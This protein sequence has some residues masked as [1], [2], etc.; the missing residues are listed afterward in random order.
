MYSKLDFKKNLQ[1]KTGIMLWRGKICGERNPMYPW[2]EL[3]FAKPHDFGVKDVD[4]EKCEDSK[5][6]HTFVLEVG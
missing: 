6:V 4:F 5:R 1:A 2:K 3:N